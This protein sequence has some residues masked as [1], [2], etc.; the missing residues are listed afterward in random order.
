MPISTIRFGDMTLMILEDQDDGQGLNLESLKFLAE[1]PRAMEILQSNPSAQDVLSDQDCFD[2]W[3]RLCEKKQY[4]VNDRIPAKHF[5]P[6]NLA[7]YMQRQVNR[8]LEGK[9][10]RNV[11][12]H[13]Q[14]HVAGK[15]LVCPC[16]E[17]IELCSNNEIVLKPCYVD[18]KSLKYIR[19]TLRNATMEHYDHVWKKFG[20]PL[21]KTSSILTGKVHNTEG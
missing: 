14:Y 15:S 7:Y 17:L 19:K 6:A 1:N 9:N 5:T 11:S 12:R 16:P 8:K 18:A 21:K 13:G 20:E 3:R 10:E 2:F 4:A